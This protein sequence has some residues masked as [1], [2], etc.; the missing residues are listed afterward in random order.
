MPGFPEKTQEVGGGLPALP[1]P[2]V[3]AARERWL[4]Q[5]D[6][7]SSAPGSEKPV[8]ELV[9]S[10]IVLGVRSAFKALPP[11]QEQHEN[12]YT[13]Q[14]HEKECLE[15]MRV[16]EDM[17]SMRKVAG[18]PP[19][20]AHIQPLHAV[21]KPGKSARVCFDL[22]R[23]FN[24]M[25]EDETFSMASVQDAVDLAK[26]AGRQPWFAKLDISSCFLSFPIHPDDLHFFYCQA[27][28]DFYQFLTLVFGRKDAPRVVTQ[29][30]DV[31]SS[32]VTDSGVPH[33]RYLDDF[34]LAATTALRAWACAFKTATVLAEFG[35]ALSLSK[36][37]GP[38]QRM[39][40]LGVVIDSIKETMEISEERKHELLALLQAF[41]KRKTSSVKRLMSL[42][43][44]LAFAA[45]VL[46]G[47]KPFLRRVIDTVKGRKF[48]LRRLGVDFKAEC[49]YWAAHMSAWNGTA[50]WRAPATV[51]FVFAS[52]ASTSGF[53]Y[54]LES[55]SSTQLNTLPA[56]MR[57]GDVRSGSWSM[58]NG[59]AA[60]QH[61]SAAI[62]WGE[63]FCPLAAV[64]EFGPQ[65][66]N[67][68]VVFVIDNESDVHVINRLRSRE[69]R[70]ANLLRCLC[71]VSLRH[72]FSFKA[73]HRAGVDNVLMDWA[74]RPNYHKF[75]AMP[76]ARLQAPAVA[77]GGA[78]AVA[79][80]L[81][82]YP[83][84]LHPSSITHISS[85]CLMFESKTSLASWAMASGGWSSCVA[86]S[87]S[88]APR[89]TA[90]PATRISSCDAVRPSAWTRCW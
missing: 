51:P 59:D 15:R 25:L 77:C 33:V 56:G 74:S 60:R 84:L 55:C 62:Q 17:G 41:G 37:E 53:A 79:L 28:G 18:L 27:G 75:A 6:K 50:R 64:V 29:L 65:L 47:A 23:N 49:R 58:S 87:T 45:T 35:L 20:G 5:I 70:V 4:A 14:K 88:L 82:A 21:V 69:P 86:A 72:N 36:F 7:L 3:P 81:S 63:F 19:E 83:P 31:V 54:G 43:G 46:P 24:D 10:M 66:Q 16:Y 80:G 78:V 44:K 40:F 42:L 11:R 26:L 38:L 12:T 9:R 8:L 71:D 68:H 2:D 90:T 85:R 48:G 22:A 57:P 30:L 52:D 67:S 89:A 39:E 1:V 34:F 32:A 61:T 73:V 13:F 76:P